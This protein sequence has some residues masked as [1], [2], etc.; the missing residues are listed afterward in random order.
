MLHAFLIN[1]LQKNAQRPTQCCCKILCKNNC[2]TVW[3]VRRSNPNGGEIFRTRP[4]QPVGPNQPRIKWLPCL[5]PGVK[6]PMLGVDH[7][8]PSRTEVE[9]RV[10]LYF[11]YHLGFHSLFWD[12]I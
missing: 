10:D 7:Q 12:E 8:P 1:I 6:R 2:A 3:R 4:V 11:Y 5:F 9:E